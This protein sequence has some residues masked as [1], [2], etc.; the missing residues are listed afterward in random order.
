MI[1]VGLTGGIGSGKSTVA[2]ILEVLGVPVF[3]ADE[4][5]KRALQED[6]A[7][8]RKVT[9]AFGADIYPGGVLDRR[10]L[11][12]R[13]FHDPEAVARLNGI[14]HPAV[15]ERFRSWTLQQRAPYVVMEAAVLVESGGYQAFDHL[16]V[17]TAPEE[18]RLAR[19]MQRDG[20]S[21]DEV[22]AR[23]R[24]QVTEEARAAVAHTVL[25]NDGA[26]L[27]V[28]QVIAL[29]HRMIAQAAA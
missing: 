15:R 8:V 4:E 21:A 2:R 5:G 11:A 1:T 26:T 17:V 25:I 19:V 23:M 9:D 7:V 3:L 24:N 18:V 10:T 6:P 22:R 16:A 27:L 12:K 29:H 28:P 14:V 13:V 20:S